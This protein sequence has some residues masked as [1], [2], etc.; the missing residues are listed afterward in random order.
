MDFNDY[1]TVLSN[2]WVQDALQ[3]SLNNPYNLVAL[4][5]IIF[6]EAIITI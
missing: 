5:Y 1:N 6:C 3:S 4:L 2:L